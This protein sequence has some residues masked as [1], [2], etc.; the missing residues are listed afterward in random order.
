[1][2]EPSP[3]EKFLAAAMAVTEDTPPPRQDAEGHAFEYV[4][5]VISTPATGM[6][7]AVEMQDHKTAV[8]KVEPDTEKQKN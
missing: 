2:P 1:M 3:T 7:M 4:D 5:A 8:L 6:E